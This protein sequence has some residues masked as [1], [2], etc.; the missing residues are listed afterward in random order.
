MNLNQSLIKL[1]YFRK[2]KKIFLISGLIIFFVLILGLFS[3]GYLKFNYFPKIIIWAWERPENL[4][5][6]KDKNIGVAFYV[7]TI[8]FSDSETTFQ[9]RLQPLAIN[10]KPPLMAVIRMI[11]KESSQLSNDQLLKAVDWI[12]KICSQKNISG[13]Q[14]DFD[15][16]SSEINF[17]EKLIF[18]TRNNLPKSMPLSI[19]T[20]ASWCHL[21][22]WLD[23]LPINEAVPMFYRLG[24]DEYLIKH[25]LVGE[26]FMKAKNCQKAIGISIDEPLPQSK[27]LKNRRIYIYN[28]NSWTFE[29]F[30]NIM[31]EIKEKL[32]E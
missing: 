26:S 17:Y 11:N 29:D 30:S 22:S 32:K 7:G 21:G 24:P 2:S 1:I 23:H 28:P 15:V 27:Y 3:F 13:C 20:L 16:K 8:I 18:E 10:P 19:T 6:I 14:I 5:F 25:G 31:K 9:P 4:L 12:I